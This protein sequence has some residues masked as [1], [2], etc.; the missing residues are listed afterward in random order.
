VIRIEHIEKHPNADRLGIVTLWGGGYSCVVRLEDF[1]AG[2]L[3]V[4]IPPDSIC[5][6]GDPRFA[7]L[8]TH[9][10]IRASKLRG[11]ISMGLLIPAPPGSQEGED[12]AEALGITHYEPP[13]KG[14]PGFASGAAKGAE[15]AEP[16]P[17]YYPIYDME[18]LRRYADVF[19]EGEEVV[20]TEKLHGCSYRLSHVDRILH[21][22]SHKRWKKRPLDGEENFWWDV[23]TGAMMDLVISLPSGSCLYGEVFGSV[24]KGFSY[25]VTRPTFAL[26]DIFT[27]GRW[28]DYDE[29]CSLADEHGVPRVPE[30]F[31]GPFNLEHVLNLAEGPSTVD[32]A[33]HIREGCVVRAIR[34]RY[35]RRVGR[36]VLKAVGHGY[37]IRS[38]L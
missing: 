29:L 37:W 15:D 27:N 23:M 21:V 30:L 24:Q 5:P 34:E 25:G 16:P 13:V 20:L 17:G 18:S 28:L 22:G 35:D 10:R 26:F 12:L 33:G 38:D 32:N 14:F 19:L 7:F 2:D 31:R 11:I 4:Y 6:E 8:G 36:A 9:R 3:A 1:N